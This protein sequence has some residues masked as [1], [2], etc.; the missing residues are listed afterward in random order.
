MPAAKTFWRS[1]GCLF[2]LT[3][4]TAAFPSAA[5]LNKKRVASEADLPR[6]SYPLKGSA[7]AL[8]EA[9]D[10][11]FNAFA[12]KVRAD[13]DSIF[14]NYEIDDK[15]TLRTLTGVKF[16][17]QELAGDDSA[18]LG[19][20]GQLRLLQEKPEARLTTGL[21]ARAQ[22]EAFLETKSTHGAAFDQAFTK[23]YRQGVDSLPWNLA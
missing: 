5:P 11:I 20:L 10:A 17:L 22:L 23:R 12:D 14:N 15:A 19:T 13:L 16:D 9:D 21:G 1:S 2:L 7:S 8:L 18:A 3:A 6:F 4:L